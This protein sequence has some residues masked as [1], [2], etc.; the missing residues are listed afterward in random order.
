[1]LEILKSLICSSF[2]LS[3]WQ[4]DFAGRSDKKPVGYGI[5]GYIL[6]MLRDYNVTNSV[7]T[8]IGPYDE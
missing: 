8:M 3:K 6:G 5:P 4:E 1:M 2:K 7:V